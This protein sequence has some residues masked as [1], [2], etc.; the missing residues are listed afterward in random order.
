LLEAMKMVR[1]QEIDSVIERDTSRIPVWLVDD[2]KHY[3][4]TVSSVLNE[5][6]EVECT[7]T[8]SRCEAA[9]EALQK[10]PSPPSVILLD[11][12]MPGIG[13][14][15]AIEPLKEISPLTSILMITVYNDED[16]IR[17][18]M[19]QG[20]SG[21]LLK[22]SSASEFIRAIQNVVNGG[23]PVDPFV[24]PKMMKIMKM[25]ALERTP[26]S[27]YGLTEREKKFLRHIANGL[28]DQQIATR[29]GVSYNTVLYHTKNIHEKLNVHSRRELIAKAHKE[30]LI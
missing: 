7:R 11:I 30:R 19:K 8:F 10:E 2:N 4:E 29:M 12:Q 28:N 13:G 21:Y 5:S 3:S 20:A 24:V 14:L 15:D 18:A 26:A 22:Q 6:S 16:Y 17:I 27:V 1:Q 25:A 23:M 9:I